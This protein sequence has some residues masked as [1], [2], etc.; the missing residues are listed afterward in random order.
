MQ[1]TNC[2]TMMLRF[3][4]QPL[5]NNCHQ[6][7]KI[8][9]VDTLLG[10]INKILNHTNTIPFLQLLKQK[11]TLP[12][13][14]AINYDSDSALL[15]YYIITVSLVFSFTFYLKYSFC[16]HTDHRSDI[17]TWTYDEQVQKG[18]HMWVACPVLITD[19]ASIFPL[20][21]ARFSKN[22]RKNPKFC[23]SFS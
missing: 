19:T 4:N 21:G 8:S 14:I 7:V 10:N 22:L 18:R 13:T 11:I 2:I 1:L 23:V 3:H 20:S 17:L 6:R 16:F 9:D 12:L 15:M 5:T